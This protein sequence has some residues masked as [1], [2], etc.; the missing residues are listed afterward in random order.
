MNFCAFYLVCLFSFW[1]L[2][3]RCL[4]RVNDVI[5]RNPELVLYFNMYDMLQSHNISSIGVAYNDGD[6]SGCRTF[7][8]CS[9][10]I[11]TDIHPIPYAKDPNHIWNVWDWRRRAIEMA[12]VERSATK[13]TQTYCHSAHATQTNWYKFN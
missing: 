13:S 4:N 8:H 7:E 2:N 1:Y 3:F 10:G 11:Q 6:Q 12:N 5:C 9:I